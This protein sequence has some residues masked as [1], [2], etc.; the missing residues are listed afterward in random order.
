MKNGDREPREAAR[1]CF[2]GTSRKKKEKIKFKTKDGKISIR[3]RK[4]GF[5]KKGTAGHKT[6]KKYN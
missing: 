6:W 5:A 4:R 2:G 3:K 1:G